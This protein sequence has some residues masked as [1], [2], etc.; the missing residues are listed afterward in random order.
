MYPNFPGFAEEGNELVQS[1]YGKN[2]ERLS[3]IK[4]KY[5]PDNFFSVNL[6]IKPA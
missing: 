3:K 2:Y 4:A 1:A 5:D 6:N